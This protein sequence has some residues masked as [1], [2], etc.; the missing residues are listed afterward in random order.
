M[1]SQ[2]FFWTL[3]LLAISSIGYGQQDADTLWNKSL[4][5]DLKNDTLYDHHGGKIFVG[6]TLI[7]GNNATGTGKYRSIISKWAAIVPSIWGPDR[8]YE[9]EI[10]NY[11]DNKKGKASLLYLTPGL[12]LTIKK[13]VLTGNRKY[14][15]YYMVLLSTA[16]N[17]YRADIALALRLRELLVQ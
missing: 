17:E 7:L 5:Y 13:I 9:N 15:R 4:L 11:V 8:R 16:T 12:P 3:T 1:N 6:Q 14:T 10:E 2:Y